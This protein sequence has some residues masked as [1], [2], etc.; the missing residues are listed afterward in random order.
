MTFP[1]DAATAQGRPF[2]EQARPGTVL[3]DRYELTERVGDGGH[4]TVWRAHD[5]LLRRDVAVK[6]VTLP[7]ELPPDERQ[8]RCERTLR[9]AQAAASL[10]HPSVV[11]VF[12]VINE[13]GRPWIVMEL[14]EARSLAT[15][16]SSSGPMPARVVAKIGLALTG[17]LEAA[18]AAGILHR[19][20]KPGN[21]LISSDGRCVLS[22]FGAAAGTAGT[23]HTAPGMVLGS[24]HYIAPERA[25]GGQAEPAS[26]LFSLGVTL[27]AALEGRP[28]FDRGDTTATMQA[29]VH[30][31]PEAPRHA[32]VLTPLLGGLL[33][34][35]PT[36]RYTTAT[37]R[38][39][40]TALLSGPLSDDPSAPPVSGG[41]VSGGPISGIPSSAG[42][43]G[44]PPQPAIPPGATQ[45]LPHQQPPARV[46]PM[47]GAPYGPSNRQP[48]PAPFTPPGQY[49]PADGYG[50]SG[51]GGPGG[52]ASTGYAERPEPK[53][54]KVGVLLGAGIGVVVLALITIL[55]IN[56]FSGPNEPPTDPDDTA[57]NEQE[58]EHSPEFE[59]EKYVDPAGKFNVMVPKGWKAAVNGKTD[60]SDPEDGSVWLRF[61]VTKETAP[62]NALVSGGKWLKKHDFKEY[63]Q[64]GLTEITIAGMDGWMLEYKGVNKQDVLRHGMWAIVTDGEVGYHVYM[65]VPDAKFAECKPYFDTAA[66]TFAVGE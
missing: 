39:T 41:P 32:G 37:T 60:I 2:H 35:D 4:G 53:K 62:K 55:G 6:E 23:G 1:P 57:T 66:A 25:I 61:N 14:L 64:V 49:G 42:A 16:I 47:T 9:E 7:P 44:A 18:H 52:Y 40:L 54:S 46:D 31:Q 58:P 51:P 12:D 45:L 63:E 30:D 36:K 20:V 50:P 22:D 24:A 8:Q 13:G 21:V 10:S 3:A 56:M 48:E 38:N 65:S 28:P 29:V 11:R 27:Y 26:D 43:Y 59:A 17:A 19:D 33:E 5:R 34:K 15:I